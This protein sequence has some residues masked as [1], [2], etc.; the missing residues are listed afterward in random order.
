[1]NTYDATEGTS[2]SDL[3]PRFIYDDT[4]P[5]ITPERLAELE[6][7]VET[8]RRQQGIYTADDL[9]AAGFSASEIA[10]FEQGLP[11]TGLTE[12]QVAEN[13]ETYG[14]LAEAPGTIQKYANMLE[15]VK[16]NPDLTLA[17][18]AAGLGYSGIGGF[19]EELSLR[20]QGTGKMADDALSILG[21]YN[22]DQYEVI[23]PA[24][25]ELVTVDLDNKV[26]EKVD[27]TFVSDALSGV[28]E[29]LDKESNGAF[30]KMPQAYRDAVKAGMPDPNNIGFTMD[31]RRI[32]DPS[33]WMADTAIQELGGLGIDVAAMAFSPVVGVP[34]ALQQNIAEAGAAASNDVTDEMDAL[35]NTAFKDLSDKDFN[36]LKEAA[37]TQGFYTS[38]VAGGVVDTMSAAL[39]LGAPKILVKALPGVL[40][41]VAGVLG[42]EFV[43]GGSE[44]AGVNQ[45]IISAMKAEGLNPEDYGVD[46]LNG[47]FNAAWSEMF[48]S[49]PAAVGTTF[50]GNAAGNVDVGASTAGSSLPA[51]AGQGQD[52]NPNVGPDLIASQGLNTIESNDVTDSNGVVYGVDT[53]VDANGNTSVTV[54]NKTTNTSK[55][56]NVANGNTNVV[57]VGIGL[58][59]CLW[60]AP[61]QTTRT[62]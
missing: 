37:K 51:G 41:R 59:V 61:I 25:G 60:T 35:R 58:P 36:E 21:S 30:S 47:T 19:L 28:V 4:A 46:L 62:L 44:Q 6:S 29:Y 26:Q 45:A 14:S 31:G 17:E 53:A 18:T 22:L 9:D 55:T 5:S 2:F 10:A 50:Q 3:E 48:G 42:S 56:T 7:Y 40:T 27:V 8:L 38:G 43:A 52:N 15:F 24:T 1:M 33:L 23:D 57:S 49:G 34:L 20:V 13:L 16:G 11:A 54:T 39:A 32:T 12:A